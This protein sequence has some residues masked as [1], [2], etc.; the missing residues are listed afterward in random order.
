MNACANLL[1]RD[2]KMV[3]VGQDEPLGPLYGVGLNIGRKSIAGSLIGL[4]ETQEMLY[5]YEE[6]NVICD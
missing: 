6:H 3:I 4:K 1:K 5:F 2:A